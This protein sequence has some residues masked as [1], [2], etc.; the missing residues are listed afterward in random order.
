MLKPFTTPKMPRVR[1]D[2]RNHEHFVQS[3]EAVFPYL[4]EAGKERVAIV[5]TIRA[6]YTGTLRT[7]ALTTTIEDGRHLVDFWSLRI[8]AEGAKPLTAEKPLKVY[9]SA[10]TGTTELWEMTTQ[11][12]VGSGVWRRKSYE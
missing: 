6:P 12:D 8:R 2:G 4:S 11:Y 3:I 9:R 1:L 7:I 10:S 5:A